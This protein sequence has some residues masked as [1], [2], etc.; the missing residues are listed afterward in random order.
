MLSFAIR[1]LT[2]QEHQT[3]AEAQ[4]DTTPHM[5]NKKPVKKTKS[6]ERDM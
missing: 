5:R 3:I 1:E 6:E 4:V 2:K